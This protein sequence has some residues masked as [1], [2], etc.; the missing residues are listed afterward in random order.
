VLHASGGML[1]IEADLT[2]GQI[3]IVVLEE[4]KES[5]FAI[6]VS[7]ELFQGRSGVLTGRLCAWHTEVVLFL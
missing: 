4:D 3:S 2:I 5:D 7:F 1:R 6:S